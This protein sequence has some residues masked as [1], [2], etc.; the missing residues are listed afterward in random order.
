[1]DTE[2]LVQHYADLKALFATARFEVLSSM[3]RPLTNIDVIIPE[4]Q[5]SSNLRKRKITVDI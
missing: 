1:M 2:D 5:N 4:Q 3:K